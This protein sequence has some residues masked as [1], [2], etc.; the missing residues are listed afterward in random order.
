MPKRQS[1]CLNADDA[2]P[3]TRGSSTTPHACARRE[4]VDL[5]LGGEVRL[6]LSGVE[7]RRLGAVASTFQAISHHHSRLG[8]EEVLTRDTAAAVAVAAAGRLILG[9]G[10]VTVAL[11]GRAGAARAAVSLDRILGAGLVTVALER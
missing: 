4:G 9:S 3:S 6:V 7:V 11:A 1:K 2:V 5:S 8:V 10:A